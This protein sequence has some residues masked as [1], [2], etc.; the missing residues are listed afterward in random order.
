MKETIVRCEV[1][2]IFGAGSDVFLGPGSEQAMGAIDMFIMS[3][4][5][6]V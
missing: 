4:D 3:M 2:T 6:V 5:R 1:Q